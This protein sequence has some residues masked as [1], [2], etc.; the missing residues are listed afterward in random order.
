MWVTMMPE[1]KEFQIANIY[2]SKDKPIFYACAGENI[3]IK[4]RGIE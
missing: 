2:D 4:V 1:K 3:K